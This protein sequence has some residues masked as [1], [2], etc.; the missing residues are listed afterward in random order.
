MSA[1]LPQTR[2]ELAPV[3][4]AFYVAGWVGLAFDIG[5]VAVAV[6]LVRHPAPMLE[7]FAANVTLSGA[8]SLATWRRGL[9]RVVAPIPHGAVVVPG[10]VLSAR[11]IGSVLATTTTMTLALLGLVSPA[12]LGAGVGAEVGLLWSAWKV[13]EFEREDGRRV[14][15][16]THRRRGE[17]AL[18]AA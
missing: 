3:R 7:W 11:L 1:L 16:A 8:I 17:P 12:V 18:Y 6:L 10:T 13:G 5:A 2:V 4:G 9:R 14:L 15:R